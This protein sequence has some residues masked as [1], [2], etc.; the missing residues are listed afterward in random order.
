M[1]NPTEAMQRK[2][3]VKSFDEDLADL[4]G[5]MVQMGAHAERQIARAI[6]SL[7][8][9]D[10][11]LAEDVIETDRAV[12]DLE[13]TIDQHAIV[14]L[15]TRQPMAVDLR[16][17]SMSL[18][19]SND[20]ERI[21]DYAKGIAKRARRLSLSPQLKP[22]ISIPR[23]AELTQ[24][25]LKDVL[26]AYITRDAEKAMDVWHRDQTVDDEYDSLF[27]ELVTFILEDPR[28]TSTAIDL[29]FVAKNIER[30][31]DHAT[32]IAEKIHYMVHGTQ[33]NRPSRKVDLRAGNSDKAGGLAS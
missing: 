16:V 31:G 22:F 19:I 1:N 24:A 23:M 11:E 33:I 18:K 10:D 25:M 14:M 3:T 17:I 6:K 2:H 7:V 9:R 15:A 29:L 27:R 32:N 13:E 21:A 8:D 30:I 5:L 4:T 20:L 28:T 26:D 12:D